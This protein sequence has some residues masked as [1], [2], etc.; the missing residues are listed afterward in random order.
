M[1]F[2]P[3]YIPHDN[4]KKT[5]LSPSSHQ[6]PVVATTHLLSGSLNVSDS[7]II[8]GSDARSSR[9]KPGSLWADEPFSGSL[10][11]DEPQYGEK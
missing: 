3:L 2:S 8:D 7:T 11:A 9:H 4:M 6:A 5:Y 1:T 10:W